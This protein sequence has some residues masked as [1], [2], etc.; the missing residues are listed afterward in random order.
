MSRHGERGERQGEGDTHVRGARGQ[1]A[2][3]LLCTSSLFV[4]ILPAAWYKH[5]NSG[6][7]VDNKEAIIK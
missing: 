5:G 7:I 4:C 3:L 6:V 1:S 2:N